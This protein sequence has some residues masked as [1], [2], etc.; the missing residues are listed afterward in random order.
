MK[1]KINWEKTGGNIAGMLVI[2]LSAG[3]CSSKVEI[4]AQPPEQG[5][6][7]VPRAA[8]HTVKRLPLASRIP[9]VG[10]VMSEETVSLS[11]R[12]P[13][14]VSRVLAVTGSKV[15]RGATLV[16]LDDRDIK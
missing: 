9:V 14:T 11:A 2:L 10:T 5:M 12:I 8:I 1:M 16:V 6:A 3:A 7:L 13:A 4:V 15:S